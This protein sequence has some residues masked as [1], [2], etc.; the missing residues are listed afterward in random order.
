M[1]CCNPFTLKNSG[2]TGI[3]YLI[4]CGKCSFCI[5][6]RVSQ[7]S[8]RLMQQDKISISSHFITLTYDNEHCPIT[9]KGFRTLVKKDLQDFFKRLRYHSEQSGK[10]AKISYYGVGEYG[11]RTKRP[12]YH[13]IIF[14]ATDVNIGK[15]WILN[16]EQIGNLKF[17]QVSG[18]SVGYTLKYITKKGGGYKIGSGEWDDR[19][20]EFALMSKGLGANYITDKMKNWHYADKLNR[21]YV[22]LTDGKKVSMPVYYKNKI[23][24]P[25]ERK[26]IGEYTRQKKLLEAYNK[27]PLSKQKIDSIVEAAR[28]RMEYDRRKGESL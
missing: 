7:W 17:G 27:K 25:V 21:M 19:Q 6:K 10:T 9:K 1:D 8:F 5:K 3:D 26:L 13:C 24:E 12:H 16:G 20:R 23:Y 22:N 28:L 11:G 4:P 15:S 14:N 2:G 18:A